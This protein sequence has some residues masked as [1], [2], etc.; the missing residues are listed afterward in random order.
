MSR[1]VWSRQLRI[2]GTDARAIED[3]LAGALP[4]DG[5]QHAGS[6][7][8]RGESTDGLIAIAG[9]LVDALATR[10][11]TGDEE[12]IAELGHFVV[13]TSSGLLPLPV[14]LE[15]LGEALDQSGGSEAAVDLVDGTVWPADLLDIHEG[16]ED[17]DPD[18]DRWLVVAGHGSAPG[19]AD[20]ERFTASVD[21]P[22]IAARLDDTLAGRGAFRRFRS[23]LSRYEHEYTRWH[24]FRDDARLG[25]ARAWLADRGYRSTAG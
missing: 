23:E 3:V 12:L 20:M 5:L 11:W 6:A 24:R 21:D 18:S 10:G 13:E 7:I 14:E 17:F 22:D 1:D 19:Y 8:L 2:A 4:V 9:Q 25:R 15:Q 16:P